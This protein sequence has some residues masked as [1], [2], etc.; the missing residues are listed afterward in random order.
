MAQRQQQQRIIFSDRDPHAGTLAFFVL[1]PLA[2][3]AG[4][5]LT[6]LY[7]A[8]VGAWLLTIIKWA[9]MHMGDFLQ[10][11][12]L[13]IL[14]IIFALICLIIALAAE[15]IANKVIAV[16]LAL[17][18]AGIWCI[19][20]LG[21]KIEWNT[22]LLSALPNLHQFVTNFPTPALFLALPNWITGAVWLAVYALMHFAGREDLEQVPIVIPRPNRVS[23]AQ[24]APAP[25]VMNH[26]LEVAGPGVSG[27]APAPAVVEAGLSA[28]RDE[29]QAQQRQTTHPATSTIT[30]NEF[31]PSE[32]KWRILT[33]CVQIYEEALTRLYPP[34]FAKLKV[35]PIKRM[36]YT[37][38]YDDQ[39][40]TWHGRTLVFAAS[41]FEP[42]Y[43]D[44]LLAQFARCLWECNS[45]DRWLR[46]VMSAYPKLGWSGLPLTLFGECMVLPVVARGLLN[47]RDWRAERV[48]TA[49]RC[50]WACGQG[51]RLLHQIN[52]W[53]AAGLEEPDPH[54]P[55]YA[56]R[57]GHLEGLLRDEE[58][59]MQQDPALLHLPV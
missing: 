57:R 27:Y 36:R 30:L 21:F 34:P 9:L 18:I 59:Q 42:I 47:W 2:D 38:Q 32:D 5:A 51:E 41:L 4:A 13:T 3:L 46:M 12:F 7:G 31:D 10:H 48:L 1:M 58:R 33:T 37:S 40:V 44:R 20:R 25:T 39:Q 55:R 22:P 8:S 45:P 23:D 35:P 11:G 26:L 29:P 14:A 15:E 52:L 54:L 19:L 53:I 49:D 28:R 24:A 43:E 56:E 16:C 6:F 50:A 17:A